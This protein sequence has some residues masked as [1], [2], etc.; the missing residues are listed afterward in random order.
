M[1]GTSVWLEKINFNFTVQ[2]EENNLTSFCLFN[3]SLWSGLPVLKKTYFSSLGKQLQ[4]LLN[5]LVAVFSGGCYSA[6][7]YKWQ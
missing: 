5:V 7:L 1:K 2:T 6:H 3:P 4:N